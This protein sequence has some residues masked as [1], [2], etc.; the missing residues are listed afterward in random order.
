MTIL[1]I[2]DELYRSA[3][4]LFSARTDKEWGL[5]DCVSFVVM[6]NRGMTQALTADEHFSQVGYQ[7]LLN[8]GT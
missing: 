2:A 5:V 7:A 8:V 6:R 1:P 3:F 4:D